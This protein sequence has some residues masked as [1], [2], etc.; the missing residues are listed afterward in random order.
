VIHCRRFNPDNIVDKCMIR[1]ERERGA[2]CWQT[3]NGFNTDVAEDADNAEDAD[4]VDEVDKVDDANMV[5]FVS[6]DGTGN[7]S[8]LTRLGNFV[9]DRDRFDIFLN[10]NERFEF[11]VLE[12]MRNEAYVKDATLIPLEQKPK[13]T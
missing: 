11:G 1:F 10:Q 9:D 8:L 13:D 2:S 12:V 7:G 3:A 6:V 5:D 4:D